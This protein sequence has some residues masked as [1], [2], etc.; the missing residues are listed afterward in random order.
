MTLW[1]FRC[2]S[3]GW[4]MAQGGEAG[5]AKAPTQDEFYAALERFGIEPE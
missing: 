5:E 1:E 3:K 2:T 4:K